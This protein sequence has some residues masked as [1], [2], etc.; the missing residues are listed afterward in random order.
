MAFE[1]FIDWDDFSDEMLDDLVEVY[2]RFKKAQKSFDRRKTK[3]NAI[4]MLSSQGEL[5]HIANAIMRTLH[6]VP[7][8]VHVAGDKAVREGDDGPI[9]EQRCTRCGSVLQ[10]W[11]PSYHAMTPAGPIPLAEDDLPWWDKGDIVAKAGD[12]NES[13]SM[14]QIDPE[15]DLEKHERECYALDSLGLKG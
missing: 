8:M 13:M 9:T 12:E 10:R 1:P 14:Y 2:D 11:E 3:K 6:T 4:A 5:S 7:V 15:R